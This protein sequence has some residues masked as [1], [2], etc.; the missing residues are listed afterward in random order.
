MR[1][2]YLSL[3]AF[4]ALLLTACSGDNPDP[5]GPAS[6]DHIVV[7]HSITLQGSDAYQMFV[8]ANCQWTITSAADW[9]TVTPSSGTGSTNVSLNPSE[10]NGTQSRSTKLT[11]TTADGITT[12]IEVLQAP[13]EVVTKLSSND[14]FFNNGGGSQT[15]VVTSNTAWELRGANAYSWLSVDKTEGPNGTIP[16]VLT[17]SANTSPD[18]QTATLALVCFGTTE[19]T[20]NITVTLQ[21][22]NI[23]LTL[24]EPAPSEVP[25][26]GGQIAFSM[27]ANY[28][29]Q[30]IIGGNWAKF[31]ENGQTMLTGEAS[32]TPIALNIVCEPN[33]S[34]SPR[35]LTVT[36]TIPNTDK[37]VS[38]TL[39]QAAGT[40]PQVGAPTASNVLN[41]QA[42]ISFSVSSSSLPITSC[43]VEVSANSD[44]Q[45]AKAYPAEGSE[46]EG[47]VTLTVAGF[48]SGQTYYARP[49]AQNAVGRTTGTTISFTTLAVPGGDDNPTPY[50]KRQ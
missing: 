43:G 47:A 42:T 30:A 50:V 28:G 27:L 17:A 35:E 13:G 29:W 21:G 34:Q 1:T 40:L 31:S 33:I 11:L 23:D 4:M 38:R 37:S 8:D 6:R 44:M 3:F 18:N 45:D 14:I 20:Y 19:V 25:A 12:L 36:V 48:I 41:S 2:L 49:Y 10:N 26:S 16:V 9:L 22:R 5:I 7:E 32:G 15:L 24:S 39:R 46:F